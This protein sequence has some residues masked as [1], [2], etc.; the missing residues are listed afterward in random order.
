MKRAVSGTS[1]GAYSVALRLLATRELSRRQV[2]DRLRRRGFS[3]EQ[4]AAAI[5][6]LRDDGSLDDARVAL[7]YARTAARVKHQGRE[8][9]LKEIEG[10]GIGRQQARQAVDEVF[11]ELDEA[12]LI[13]L[14][15]AR[16]LRGRITSAAVFARHYRYLLRQGF[17]PAAV[18]DALRS[19]SRREFSMDTP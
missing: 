13:E 2:D 1:S 5:A 9:V 19:R 4:I 12:A 10:L 17:T 16:R 11:G 6:R 7:A 14:A 8:R 18:V 15:L 3:D